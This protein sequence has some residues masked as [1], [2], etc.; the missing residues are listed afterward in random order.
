MQ[1]GRRHTGL[2]ELVCGS[3][4]GREPLQG[5]PIAI[6]CVAHRASVVVFPAPAIPFEHPDAVSV[7]K[8]VGRGRALIGRRLGIVARIRGLRRRATHGLFDFDELP[9]SGPPR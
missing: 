1:R 9:S 3:T 5:V 4:R 7:A 6:R 8:D 2:R